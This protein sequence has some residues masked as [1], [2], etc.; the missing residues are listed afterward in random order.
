MTFKINCI[1]WNKNIK[2]GYAFW[3]D[4]HRSQETKEKISIKLKGHIP[5][6]KGKTNIYSGEALKKMK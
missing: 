6:N 4:K 5:W 1:P 2:T 3:K